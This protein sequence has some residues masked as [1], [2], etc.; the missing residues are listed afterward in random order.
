MS[1]KLFEGEEHA[2]IYSQSRPGYPKELIER[3]IDFVRVTE[4]DSSSL[5]ID[6]GC[7][8]GQ[9]THLFSPYF[10]RIYGFDVSEN[11][12]KEARRMSK[13]EK[14][15]FFVSPSETLPLERETTSLIT[16]ATAIHWFNIEAFF[17]ECDRILKPN[18]VLAIFL[19]DLPTITHSP[20]LSAFQDKL[21][22]IY[23]YLRPYF[24]KE[25]EIYEQKYKTLKPPFKEIERDILFKNE[26][27]WRVEHLLS[28]IQSLSGYQTFHAKNPE[29]N[30]IHSTREEIYNLFKQLNCAENVESVEFTV[31]FEVTLI[32]C[33][34]C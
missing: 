32:L 18:G 20:A 6:V 15:S 1:V 9:V 2:K 34:K 4:Y 21:N 27:K 3:I 23:K 14:V 24:A 8:N 26:I 5:A 12:I 31:N 28:F 7:G 33:R 19:Y 10:D 29:N 11:Q 25:F 13:N 30:F 22:E 16:V 17:A